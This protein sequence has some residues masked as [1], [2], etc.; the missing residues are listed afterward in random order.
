[1]FVTW[2]RLN[3]D[4]HVLEC[5]GDMENLAGRAVGR[6]L[7][8]VYPDAVDQFRPGYELAFQQGFHNFACVYHDCIVACLCTRVDEHLLVCFKTLPL[9]GLTESLAAVEAALRD[10]EPGR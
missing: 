5:D 10:P 7:F 8:D 3:R 1:M 9:V 4:M 2:L 6:N